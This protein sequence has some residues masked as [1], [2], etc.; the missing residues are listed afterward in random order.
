MVSVHSNKTLIKTWLFWS[1]FVLLRD[2]V[3]YV[4]GTGRQSFLASVFIFKYKGN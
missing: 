1:L 4:E 3:S 2:E